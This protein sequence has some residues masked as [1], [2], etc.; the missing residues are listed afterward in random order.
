MYFK[1]LLINLIK[2]F[3]RN[4]VHLIVKFLVQKY[5]KE[6]A[7][8]IGNKLYIYIIAMFT[9]NMILYILY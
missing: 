7:L 8:T 6:N 3:I 2:K 4:I 9:R 5:L 1:T